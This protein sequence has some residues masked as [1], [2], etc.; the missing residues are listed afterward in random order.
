MV[1]V[2]LMYESRLAELSVAFLHSRTENGRDDKYNTGFFALRASA[3]SFMFLEQVWA[4]N[5]FGLGQS[6]QASINHCLA[7]LSNR[8]RIAR[9]KFYPRVLLNAFPQV[10]RTT[11]AS[12]IHA[13][14]S[15]QAEMR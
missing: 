11:P 7:L 9:V 13:A 3:W 15:L 6:D 2:L 1:P 4:H 10:K 8:E 14:S 12:F 5:D